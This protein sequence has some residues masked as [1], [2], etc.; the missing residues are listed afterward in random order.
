MTVIPNFSNPYIDKFLAD[1]MLLLIYSNPA[2]TAYDP[3][4]K[5]Y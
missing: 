2:V 3:G 1:Y 4:P 5:K